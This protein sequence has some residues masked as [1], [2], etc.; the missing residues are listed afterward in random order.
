METTSSATENKKIYVCVDFLDIS[1]AGNS[2]QEA[3]EN[4]VDLADAAPFEELTF[5]RATPI[6]VTTSITLK[7][8]TDGS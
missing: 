2:P 1:G 7:G 6:V 8:K 5:Y 3:Y 4:Y